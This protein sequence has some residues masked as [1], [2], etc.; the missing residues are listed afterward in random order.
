MCKPCVLCHGSGRSQDQSKLYNPSLSLE[1]I[2][3]KEC[4]GRGYSQE[5]LSLDQLYQLLSPILMED[6][7]KH[8]PEIIA[9]T[10]L[11]VIESVMES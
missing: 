1:D 6:V 10:Q 11:A 4:R 8:L 3:C 9:K 2:R 5:F 7:V